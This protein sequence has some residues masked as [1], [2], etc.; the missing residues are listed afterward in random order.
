M[1]KIFFEGTNSFPYVFSP[2][3]EDFFIEGS[4]QEVIKV[5]PLL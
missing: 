4:K 2:I 1:E 3:S 5:V